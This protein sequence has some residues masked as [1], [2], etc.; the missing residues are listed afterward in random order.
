MVVWGL[1]YDKEINVDMS[2]IFLFLKLL[3][4]NLNNMFH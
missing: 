3:L 4:N 1:I 2:I